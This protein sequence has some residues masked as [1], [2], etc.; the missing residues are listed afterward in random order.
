MTIVIDATTHLYT[1][2]V[3]IAPALTIAAATSLQ[4]VAT[5]H[6]T[7]TTPTRAVRIRFTLNSD[8]LPYT[9]YLFNRSCTRGLRLF[10]HSG[11]P[12]SYSHGPEISYKHTRDRRGRC[13]RRNST[14]VI[15]VKVCSSPSCWY[16]FISLGVGFQK[17]SFMTCAVRP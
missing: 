11:T 12:Q 6:T 7:S 16:P 2:C 8:F 13:R 4:H 3:T 17:F 1:S 9:T 5:L 15:H 14:H 10:S